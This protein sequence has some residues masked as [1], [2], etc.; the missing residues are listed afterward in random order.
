M[1]MYLILVLLLLSCQQVYSDTSKVNKALS[2]YWQAN[3][4]VYTLTD[5][6]TTNTIS[7]TEIFGKMNWL[8]L[9]NLSIH[10]Q[11]LI[12]G[13][14]GFSQSIYDRDDRTRG[15]HFLEGFLK[16]KHAS[17]FEIRFGNIKQ[18]FLQS[19]LLITDK[20]FPSLIQKFSWKL[21]DNLKFNLLF[22]QSIPDNATEVVRRAPQII[23]TPF[24][25]TSSASWDWT[26]NIINRNMSLHQMLNLFYFTNLSSAV[27]DKGRLYGNTISYSG[28]DSDFKYKFYGFYKILKL[29]IPLNKILLGELGMDFLINLGARKNYNKG[30]RVYLSLYQNYYD[31]MEIKLTGEYFLNQS[32]SSVAYY[33]SELH[34]H[35]NR[36]G[37]GLRLETYL[38][39]SGINLGVSYRYSQP[40]EEIKTVT[41]KGHYFLVH[42]GTNYVSI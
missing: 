18:D 33:N 37:G 38:Y 25:L 28:S 32:D 22:Q 26:K 31:F 40:I 14:N 9:D 42:I 34:G 23:S 21:A 13:R 19:P 20:T 7:S 35:N 36:I 2:R 12:I 27:A 30:E 17:F 16:Y 5:K 8:I 10:V 29:K 11:G 3:F 1:K 4:K 24:F 39:R 6:S 15:F 41:G